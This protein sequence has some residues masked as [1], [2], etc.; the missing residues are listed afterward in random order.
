ML[1]F[2]VGLDKEAAVGGNRAPLLVALLLIGLATRADDLLEVVQVVDL[3][4]ADLLRS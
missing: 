1:V 4:I 2:R 3:L